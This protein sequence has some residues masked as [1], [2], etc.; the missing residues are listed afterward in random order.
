MIYL[1]R[2]GIFYSGR[3]P[4]IVLARRTSPSV[5]IFYAMRRV[6]RSG[7][8]RFIVERRKVLR[9][10]R[11]NGHC[12]ITIVRK[13]AI[14]VKVSKI[15]GKSFIYEKEHHKCGRPESF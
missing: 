9:A 6:E 13:T 2:K 15:H 10:C 12:P 14:Y 1:M 3:F 5:V 11:N 4:S 8:Y 7:L